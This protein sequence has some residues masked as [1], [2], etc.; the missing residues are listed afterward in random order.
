MQMPLKR[1]YIQHRP[2]QL[3]LDYIKC[4]LSQSLM[5]TDVMNKAALNL[6]FG[7]CLIWSGQLAR[8]QKVL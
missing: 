3:S 8:L 6:S 2:A 4:K 7:K 5:D 1:S